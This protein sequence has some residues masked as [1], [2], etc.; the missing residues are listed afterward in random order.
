VYI[1]D[2]VSSCFVPGHFH[3]LTKPGAAAA[4]HT[5]EHNMQRTFVL[6]QGQPVL[7]RVPGATRREIYHKMRFAEALVK[8]RPGPQCRHGR[9]PRAILE[10]HHSAS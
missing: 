1:T 9:P 4:L 5:S 7:L 6:F 2:H 8:V 10:D 3:L